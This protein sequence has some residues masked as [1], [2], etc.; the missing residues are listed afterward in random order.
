M[1]WNCLIVI[2]LCLDIIGVI[3]VWY[4][5]WP[6]PNLKTGVGL[7]LE[8]ATPYDSKGGSVADHNNEIDR[9]RNRYKNCSILGLILIIVGFGLQ[10]IAQIV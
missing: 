3:I 5:G 6:Q 7:A 10:L 1:D 4:Y 2:G 9:K 8:D